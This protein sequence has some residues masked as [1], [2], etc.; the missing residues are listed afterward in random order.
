IGTV[1]SGNTFFQR[2]NDIFTGI[3]DLEIDPASQ[4]RRYALVDDL[5]NWG[6]EVDRLASE[7]QKFRADADRRINEDVITINTNIDKIYSIS[8]D[9]AK[10]KGLGQETSALEEERQRSITEMGK[11]IDIR[12]FDLG[13][14][15]VNV[16]T[17]TGIGLVD[18]VKY[19]LVYN[20]TTTVSASTR[21]NQIQVY[22]VDPTS[23][24]LSTTYKVLDPNLTGGEIKGL[25][26]MR[27]TYLPYAAVQLGEYASKA[28]DQINAA[29]NDNTAVP[30]PTSLTGRNSGLL[31]TDAHGFTGGA[32]FTLVNTTSN[33]VNRNV[34]IDF[35]NSTYSINGAAAVALAGN[36]VTD[37]VTGLNTALGA[38]GSF[39]FANGVLSFS[40]TDGIAIG[41]PSTAGSSRGGRGFS[42]FFG[43]NDLMTSTA[44]ANFN[45]GFAS[46]NAHGIT[47]GSTTFEV[48]SP[49]NDVVATYTLTPGAGGTFGNIFTSLNAAAALGNYATFGFGTNGQ[50]SVTMASGYGTYKINVTS[51]TTVRG[52]SAVTL[53]NLLGIGESYRMQQALGVGPVAR[54]GGSS[55][56]TGNIALLATGNVNSTTVGQQAT[57]PGDNGGV[58][59]LLAIQTSTINY[60]SAG[61][62][63][64]ATATMAEY[65]GAIL[66]R[67]SVNAAT[68]NSYAKHRQV[69]LHEIDNRR[70][71]VSGVNLDEELANVQLFQQAYNASA[72]MITTAREMY[73]QLLLIAG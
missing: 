48:R 33:L 26:E 62:L 24:S 11:L 1:D 37:L 18:N 43:L 22:R 27:D 5:R 55:T 35:T 52:A 40:G 32:N 70:A 21:F 7:I 36:T 69:L 25:M 67:I 19:K 54:I 2:L 61:D 42:Q 12:T 13:N 49:T 44:L 63:S 8:V 46:A 10:A 53:S 66:Q 23:G 57:G 4:V 68:S 51:D 34:F 65:G 9:I 50:L 38:N 20:P 30:P 59:D 64:T 60:A 3:A 56:V 39:T 72:K 41:Q 6:L 31:G 71:A 14:G 16:S 47:S 73:D 17:S 15:Y 29:H 58:R 28:V 45:T